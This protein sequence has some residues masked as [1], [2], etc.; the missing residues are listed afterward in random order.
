MSAPVG[1]RLDGAVARLRAEP[2]DRLSRTTVDRVH[3]AL[4]VR[5]GG[6]RS[7]DPPGLRGALLDFA[8]PVISDPGILR[9]ETALALLR[10]LAERLPDAAGSD[11]AGSILRVELDRLARLRVDRNGLVGG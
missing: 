1:L 6:D 2:L 5:P 11:G 7:L 10:D 4:A 3:E 9:D 8:M